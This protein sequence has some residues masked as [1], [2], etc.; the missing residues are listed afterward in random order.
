MLRSGFRSTGTRDWTKLTEMDVSERAAGGERDWVVDVVLRAQ[1]SAEL[2]D[3][4]IDEVAMVVP[5]IEG[6]SAPSATNSYDMAPPDGSIGIS[7]W[8]RAD[9]AGEAV[10]NALSVVTEAAATVTGKQLPLWDIR[11]VPGT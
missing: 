10:E 8:I 11:L 9:S 2:Q 7:C 4:V 5:S 6:R 3:R 1:E